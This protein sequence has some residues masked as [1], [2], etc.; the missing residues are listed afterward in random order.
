MGLFLAGLAAGFYQLA[1]LAATG[2]HG[3]E[4]ATIAMNLAGQGTYGNP[5]AP[6]L[7]GPTAFVPPLYPLFLA[8]LLKIFGTLGWMVLAA[9]AIN[10]LANAAIAAM[11]PRLSELFFGDW[12]PGAFAGALWLCAMRLM[13]EWDASCTIAGLLVF[14]LATSKGARP[15]V[16][17]AIA[18]L[19]VLLNPATLLLIVPWVLYVLWRRGSGPVYALRYGGILLLVLA[20]AVAPWALRNYRIWHAFILRTSFGVTLYSSNNSCAESTLVKV[21]ANGCF[22][23]TH[24]VW[25]VKEVALLNRLGE[26]QYD[27]NRAAAAWSWIRSNPDRFRV[28][29]LERIVQFW[30]PDPMTPSYTFYGI[31]AATAL[32][33]P[34]MV[35]MARRRHAVTLYVM[36]VWLAYPLMY[37]IVV[38]CDRYRYPILWTSLLPAGYFLAALAKRATPQTCPSI[39]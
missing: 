23:A 39:E 24:P 9:S 36:A 10:I 11:L 31:W 20:A 34:G 32:S 26:V 19:L 38:A 29:T 37:Y 12:K 15:A 8:T 22:K 21:A 1:R 2:F 30:F 13:P 33:I 35:L 16:A 18:A 25:S 6:L 28:L 27:R 17:G 3:S 14:C 5:F 7:T 4:M